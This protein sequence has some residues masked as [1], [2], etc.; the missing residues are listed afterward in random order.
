VTG[1]LRRTRL[2][3]VFALGLMLAVVGGLVAVRAA[4]TPPAPAALASNGLARAVGGTS[5]TQPSASAR[6]RVHR[7]RHR[8]PGGTPGASHYPAPPAARHVVTGRAYDVGYGV[9]QVRV[10]MR[11]RHIV[12][13]A[14]LSLPSG[15]RSSDISA[16]AAPQLRREALARQSARIDTVSG[17]SYTS[18]GYAQSLQSAL[19]RSGA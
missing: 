13:V 1:S 6:P 7:H 18:A 3:R 8:G 10:T 2:R 11:G 4:L 12:D 14:A 15:G 19:D 5:S 17:A 9:V 16:Y